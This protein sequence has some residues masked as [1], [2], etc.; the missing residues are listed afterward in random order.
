MTLRLGAAARK[1]ELGSEQKVLLEP[2]AEGRR[3]DAERAPGQERETEHQHGEKTEHG[4]G[5]GSEGLVLSSDLVPGG[6][7]FA[8]P[9]S[10]EVVQLV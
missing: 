6:I 2:A 4:G 3:D 5:R 1:C 8:V 7:G 10:L 9:L